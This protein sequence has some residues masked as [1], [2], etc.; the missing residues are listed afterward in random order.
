M[1]IQSDNIDYILLSQ[2][3]INIHPKNTP[4]FKKKKDTGTIKSVNKNCQFRLVKQ[5][6]SIKN[7]AYISIF[8]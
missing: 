4:V 5:N 7:H 2:L 1:F 8:F 6:N 3:L